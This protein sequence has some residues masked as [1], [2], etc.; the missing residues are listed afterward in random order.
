MRP[1]PRLPLQWRPSLMWPAFHGRDGDIEGIVFSPAMAPGVGMNDELPLSRWRVIRSEDMCT[2]VPTIAASRSRTV[3][4]LQ[5]PIM[6]T[7]TVRSESPTMS[8]SVPSTTT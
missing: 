8:L 4:H 3:Q 7:R 2:R 5:L 6:P 1:K